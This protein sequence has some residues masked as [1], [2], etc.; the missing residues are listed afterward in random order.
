MK[1]SR[2]LP[3]FAGE[4]NLSIP[5]I[6]EHFL[7]LTK[8]H[9]KRNSTYFTSLMLSCQTDKAH[10]LKFITAGMGALVGMEN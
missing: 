9:F 6:E 3:V 8:M 4:E 2:N 7:D 1:E 5:Q 10:Q